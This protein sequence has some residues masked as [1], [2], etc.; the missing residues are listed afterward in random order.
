MLAQGVRRWSGADLAKALLSSD[1]AAAHSVVPSAEARSVRLVGG[2]DARDSG[3]VGDEGCGPLAE[4]PSRVNAPGSRGAQHVC[5]G[6][7]G[8][9]GEYSPPNL[10]IDDRIE[11]DV[12]PRSQSTSGLVN[13]RR[14]AARGRACPS[15]R[16]MIAKT[17]R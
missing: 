9:R 8:E 12:D 15:F 3:G 13:Q 5:R 17:K 16:K 2:Q 14:L 6:A 7:L 4:A 1:F 10:M 11:T